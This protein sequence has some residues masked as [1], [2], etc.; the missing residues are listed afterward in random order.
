MNDDGESNIDEA[1]PQSSDVPMDKNVE[2]GSGN[3]N[4]DVEIDADVVADTATTLIGE[5]QEEIP[6]DANHS[7]KEDLATESNGESLIPA[8]IVP[9]VIL[10]KVGTLELVAAEEIRDKIPELTPEEVAIDEIVEGTEE[11]QPHIPES[12]SEGEGNRWI[13]DGGDGN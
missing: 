8:A 2:T 13:G 6:A 4:I 7:L 12:V 1:S 5:S 9:E 3:K 10:E 11:T